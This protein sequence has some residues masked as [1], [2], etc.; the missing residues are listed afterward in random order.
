MRMRVQ[1]RVRIVLCLPT[2]TTLATIQAGSIAV[3]VFREVGR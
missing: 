1:A 2:I 3:D